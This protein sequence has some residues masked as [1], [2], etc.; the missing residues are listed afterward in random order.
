MKR[1]LIL[2]ILSVALLFSCKKETTTNTVKSE[3]KDGQLNI[4]FNN[5]VGNQPLV[6]NQMNYTNAAGNAYSATL[7][8]YYVS[9]IQLHKKGGSNVSLSNYELIDAADAESCKVLTKTLEKG[10]YDS[11]TFYIGIDGDRNHNGAQDGDLDVSNGMFWTWNT[12]YIFFKHEGTYK[13]SSNQNKSIIFHYAT[14]DAFTKVT[15][16]IQLNID[17]NKTMH[18]KFDLNSVY[19][20][21]VNIDFNVDNNRQ[22]SSS[23]DATWMANLKSNFGDAFSFMKVE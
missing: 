8:K 5:M 19:T 11:M 15:L 3:P 13:N 16:P 20:S 14:D 4:V 23:A 7:L 17:G 21:P 9:N 18:L 2:S 6:L 12:G 22:S 1:N 10:D